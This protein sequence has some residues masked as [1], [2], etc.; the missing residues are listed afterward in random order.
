MQWPLLFG[1]V[2]AVV[3]EL[4]KTASNAR[5]DGPALATVFTAQSEPVQLL[6]AVLQPL[7]HLA[8]LLAFSGLL[9]WLAADS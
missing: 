1:A 2:S 8:Q 9:F 4:G 7:D 3:A 6:E 5:W